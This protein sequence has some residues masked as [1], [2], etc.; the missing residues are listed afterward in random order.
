MFKIGQ[1]VGIKKQYQDFGD[2]VIE[3]VIVDSSPDCDRVT[4][5]ARIGLSL[6]PT[7][8]VTLDMLDLQA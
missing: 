7:Y 2:D 6:N 1:K 3:F 8:R 5:E 4:I